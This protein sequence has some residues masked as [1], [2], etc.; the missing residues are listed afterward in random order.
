[1]V[2]PIAIGFLTG[3]AIGMGMKEVGASILSSVSTGVSGSDAG[4][5]HV[6]GAMVAVFGS[7]KAL[8]VVT[9][10][11]YGPIAVR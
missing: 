11:P 10:C 2:Q 6:G 7:L 1:M 9:S 8:S 5:C 4:F 3:S